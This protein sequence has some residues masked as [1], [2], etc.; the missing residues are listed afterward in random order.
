MEVRLICDVSIVR[1]LLNKEDYKRYI[2]N[3]FMSNGKICGTLRFCDLE[4]KTNRIVFSFKEVK[5]GGI[6]NIEWSNIHDHIVKYF[7]THEPGK[8]YYNLANKFR[9][10]KVVEFNPEDKNYFIGWSHN[11]KTIR[12]VMH[13]DFEIV[14]NVYFTESS[15]DALIREIDNKNITKEQFLTAYN[16]VFGGLQ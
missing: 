3:H 10:L 9:K 11:Y 5:I 4:I 15:I 2:Y 1:K 13:M 7:G 12:K 16:E 6:L 14:N 8:D